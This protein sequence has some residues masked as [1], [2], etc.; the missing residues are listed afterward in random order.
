[1]LIT[2]AF[3]HMCPHLCV[4]DKFGCF[5]TRCYRAVLCQ[6]CLGNCSYD[7]CTSY[8][9]NQPVKSCSLWSFSTANKCTLTW[10][11]TVQ[12]SRDS[13][14]MRFRAWFRFT[15]AHSPLWGW[16]G[17]KKELNQAPSSEC[18]KS[19]VHL[20]VSTPLPSLF[21]SLTPPSLFFLRSNFGRIGRGLV[22][23]RCRHH[24]FLFCT[25]KK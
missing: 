6:F 19:H 21:L 5:V 9:N 12:D 1:M 25:V 2:S 11:L 20:K 16:I 8:R 24:T 4:R 22:R 13:C 3:G 15:D 23:T 18:E 14:W 7:N 10:D 17:E